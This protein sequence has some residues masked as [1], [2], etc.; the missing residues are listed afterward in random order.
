[1][2]KLNNERQFMVVMSLNVNL[3]TTCANKSIIIIGLFI[4]AGEQYVAM[5][6]L[7]NQT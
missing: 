1:M 2:V 6:F 3:N 4:Y 5:Q 7:S